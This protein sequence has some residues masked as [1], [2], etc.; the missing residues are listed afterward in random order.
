[1]LCDY[2]RRPAEITRAGEAN[3]PYQQDYGPV[4]ICILCYAWVGC[5]RS[6]L[7]PLGRLA[8]AELR[9]WKVRAHD[10]FDPLWR[11]VMMREGQSKHIARNAAYT[12]LAHQMGISR[13]ETH[14][15]FF[16]EQQCK[17]VVAICSKEKEYQT[18]KA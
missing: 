9:R 17:I 4:W 16:D 13:E 3:Y 1:M 11:S 14:I 15:G 5:H 18:L 6:T 12:W 2:C 10:A 7:N 8:N